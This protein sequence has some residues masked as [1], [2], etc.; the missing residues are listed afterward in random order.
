MDALSLVVLM[1]LSVFSVIYLASKLR[2]WQKYILL[3]IGSLTIFSTILD[4]FT[5]LAYLNWIVL[6][7]GFAAISIGQIC[8]WIAAVILPFGSLAYVV[9]RARDKRGKVLAGLLG[10]C[11]IMI[12][13]VGLFDLANRPIR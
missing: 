6:R 2:S 3:M 1:L 11:V 8:A 13:V 12:F 5:D 9:D 7:V 4:L 10:I